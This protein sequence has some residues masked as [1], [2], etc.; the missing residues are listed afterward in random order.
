[1]THRLP[2]AFLPALFFLPLFA[3]NNGVN[4]S[5]NKPIDPYRIA[6]NIYYVGT[7]ELS[8]FLLQ[9]FG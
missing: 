5:W 7:K 1:M 6:G 9:L 4:L 3:Q 2:R 8:S